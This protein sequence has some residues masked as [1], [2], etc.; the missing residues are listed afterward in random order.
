[1]KRQ[2]PVGVAAFALCLTIST[3]V[4]A[5]EDGTATP[6]VDAAPKASPKAPPKPID[7]T[8]E[9]RFEVV[10]PK[11]AP[12]AKPTVGTPLQLHLTITHP[13]DTT[14]GFPTLDDYGRF[15]LLEIKKPNK[16]V[17]EA[18]KAPVWKETYTLVFAS[19]RPGRHILPSVTVEILDAEGNIHQLKTKTVD[20]HVMSVDPNADKIEMP[21]LRA[22]V[23]VWHEDWTLVYILSFLGVGLLGAGIGWLI[24]KRWSRR[25]QVE[26]GPP[27]RPPYDV[28]V[29]KLRA[30]QTAGLLEEEAFEAFYVRT[31][32][33]V[34]EYLGRRYEL[35]LT[36][37]AGLE[38]TTSELMA[39]LKE[40]R[41]PSGMT[42]VEVESF[43][44]E[45]D[46]VKF[47]RYTPSLDECEKLL[48]A[49]FHIVEKTRPTVLGAD[50][51]Q[52]GEKRAEGGA[53]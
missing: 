45:C 12:D 53:S 17:G 38:L 9:Q 19:Y 49:A 37:M 43:L 2:W 5:Q 14:V 20:V 8:L 50:A 47:A 15:E 30:I 44:M 34:R 27:P 33:A 31:S 4:V 42:G 40:T 41:W 7:A 28:A 35:S 16:P 24:H 25:L 6:P 10:K 11:D 39:Q 13:S 3:G 48:A 21:P 29:E 32:E 26:V 1:M 23:S 18:A 52:D 46:L 51:L 22:P 36:D